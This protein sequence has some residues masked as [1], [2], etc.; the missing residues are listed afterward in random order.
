MKA[1]QW[2]ITAAATALTALIGGSRTSFGL[3][4]S[5]LN[6]ATGLGMAQISLAAAVGQLAAGLA[7]PIVGALARRHGTAR[8]ITVGACVLAASTAL[9]SLA[10]GMLALV[11][12]ML[13]IQT[14]GTAVASNALLLGEVSRR[15]PADERG[16]ASGIV[17]AG[18][19]AGQLLFAPPS[20]C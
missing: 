10:N 14:A 4:L 12:L 2:K 20:R 19:P 6:T 3:F 9:V 15:A 8:V 13:V 18:G 7:L 17:G 1:P 5:P 11:F 16:L